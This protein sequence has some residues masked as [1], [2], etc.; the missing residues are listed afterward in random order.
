MSA[1]KILH[2]LDSVLQIEW[3]NFPRSEAVE[4]HL[5]NIAN[6]ILSRAKNATH[7]IVSIT[8]EAVGSKRSNTLARVNFELRLPKNQ[9][10]FSQSEGYNLYEC[11]AECKQQMLRQLSSRKSFKLYKRTGSTILNAFQEA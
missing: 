4:A 1:K 9:D 6:K 8:T 2:E 3:G 7:L 10:L 5:Q 11:I